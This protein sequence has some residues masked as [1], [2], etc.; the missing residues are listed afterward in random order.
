VLQG[1]GYREKA[2]Q[3]NVDGKECK[4]GSKHEEAK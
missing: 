3:D 1:N 4:N 2:E